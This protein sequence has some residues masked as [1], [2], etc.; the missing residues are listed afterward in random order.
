MQLQQCSNLWQSGFDD[1]PNIEDWE[2][3][4]SDVRLGGGYITNL[5]D[6]D[7]KTEQSDCTGENLD[8][9]DS[10]EETFL[11]SVAGVREGSS[12][13]NYSHTYSAG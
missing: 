8:D 10:D 12:W 1:D 13:A 7:Y 3:L 5:Q 11:L 9:Q 4:T 6:G 2:A